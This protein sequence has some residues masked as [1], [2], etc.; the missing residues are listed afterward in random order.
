ML[1]LLRL[2]AKRGCP[3]V[4]A[5]VNISDLCPAF[6]F[7]CQLAA[8]L[9]DPEQIKAR[10]CPAALSLPVRLFGVESGT[11]RYLNASSI[12]RACGKASITPS[13]EVKK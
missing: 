8:V 5:D 9:A 6:H 13:L 11:R 10:N 4:F 12:V 7:D 3:F 2:G 1:N